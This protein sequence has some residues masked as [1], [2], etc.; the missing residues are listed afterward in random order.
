MEVEVLGMHIP[1]EDEDFWLGTALLSSAWSLAEKAEVTRWLQPPSGR[2]WGV[3]QPS[4][5]M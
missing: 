4:I 2:S 5:S 1:E 3:S